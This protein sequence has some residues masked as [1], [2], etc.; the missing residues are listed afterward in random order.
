MKSR[1]LITT[2]LLDTWPDTEEPVLFLGEWCLKYNLRDKWSHL[3]YKKVHYHWDDRKKFLK[4]YFYIQDLER[5]LMF[6]LSKELNRFHN[7]NHSLR[8]WKIIVGPWLN[9]FIPVL[10]DRWRMINKAVDNHEISKV[11]VITQDLHKYIPKDMSEFSHLMTTDTWNEI[12]YSDLLKQTGIP[13][14]FC[15]LKNSK[16]NPKEPL[17]GVVRIKIKSY[18]LASV[19]FI[20]N[21]FSSDK[22][23][24][25][26][27]SYFPNKFQSLLE[28]RLG[29]LP[30][31]W[32]SKTGP[33]VKPNINE[34]KLPDFDIQDFKSVAKIMIK[35][36]MPTCY[37]EGYKETLDFVNNVPWPKT[38][39]LI[40][41]SNSYFGD[42][43][44]KFYAAGKT[45][46]GSKYV[47]G[48][49]GGHFGVG[50]FNASEQYQI[51]VADKY[52][53]WGWKEDGVDNIEVLGYMKGFKRK[54]KYA[55]EGSALLICNSMPI[56]SYAMYS[57][58][59]G[60]QWLEY[61]E[62]QLTFVNALPAELQDKT[63]V[64]ITNEDYGWC[65]KERWHD[66][67]PDIRIDEGKRPISIPISKSRVCISTFNTTTYLES[68]ASNIPTIIFWNP[69]H[70][71]LRSSAVYYFKKLEEVGIFHNSP[72]AAANHLKLNWNS[73]D[74]WWKTEEVQN[75]RKEFC[76]KYVYLPD[77]A[78]NETSQLF[79]EITDHV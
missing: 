35:R 73:L 57:A 37:K 24:F 64:R 76:N 78:L 17:M 32:S 52:L 28:L 19:Q 51:S 49:H 36:H 72:E 58:P 74:E 40:F 30:K 67:L 55:K 48:Q 31:F 6:E 27:T 2:S 10:F 63:L 59:I 1:V 33:S 22:E 15:K 9:W 14:E 26:I 60:P 39:Q 23:F 47:I 7:T 66:A 3:N 50:L 77:N 54:Q 70:W 13:V 21:S 25:F 4:D 16:N 38:P 61:F 46:E 53:T 18:L 65:Q 11:K 8:Y 41:T 20:F 45:E 62:E 69:N 42:D 71:E 12:I 56:Y 43:I 34:R 5:E 79:K 75:V 68:L 44:F 29:Q